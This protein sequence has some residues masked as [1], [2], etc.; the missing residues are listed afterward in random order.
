VVMTILSGCEGPENNVGRMNGLWR[1]SGLNV[2][3]GA[4]H[5][6]GSLNE[7]RVSDGLYVEQARCRMKEL[8]GH[9]AAML[10]MSG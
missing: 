3:A 1:L 7:V 10:T 8:E 4:E 9:A 5:S 6:R 2:R